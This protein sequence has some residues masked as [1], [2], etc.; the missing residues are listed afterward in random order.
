MALTRWPARHGRAA[1]VSP[2][3][4][5]AALTITAIATDAVRELGLEPEILLSANLDR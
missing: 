4:A 2:E 3:A 5:T 1:V